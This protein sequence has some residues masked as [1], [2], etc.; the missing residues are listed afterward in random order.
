MYWLQGQLILCE[1]TIALVMRKSSIDL[2]VK[3]HPLSALS[4]VQEATTENLHL[5]ER[6]TENA[7]DVKMVKSL[8]K[9]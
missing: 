8:R 3:L 5:I 9:K 7:I 2:G 6:Q 1:T 4:T